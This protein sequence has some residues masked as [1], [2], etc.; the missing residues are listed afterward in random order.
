MR[1]QEPEHRH[2]RCEHQ[3]LRESGGVGAGCVFPKHWRSD[4]THFRLSFHG[5][6]GCVLAACALMRGSP[7]NSAVRSLLRAAR[8]RL[9]QLNVI[10]CNAFLGAC[11]NAW[12]WQRQRGGPC[13]W[14]ESIGRALWAWRSL[15]ALSAMADNCDATWTP[16]QSMAQRAFCA[17]LMLPT[18]SFGKPVQRN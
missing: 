9:L 3:C 2:L 14:G 17:E 16:M 6:L 7:H 18:P 10:A 4:F 8:R 5:G 1:R 11:Q 15:A 13:L 12:Q